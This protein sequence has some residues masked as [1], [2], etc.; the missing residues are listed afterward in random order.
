MHQRKKIQL[1]ILI[2]LLF[3]LSNAPALNT[4]QQ[5]LVISPQIALPIGIKIWFN[6]SGGSIQGLTSWN[7]GES[8]AS[9][10]IGHFI[11]YPYPGRSTEDGFPRL[12]RYMESHGIAVP[13][14]LRGNGSSFCPWNNRY[15]FYLAQN[16]TRMVELRQFLQ[17]TI[18]VQ[19]EYMSYHLAETFPQL[20]A[21]AP[22]H[23]RPYICEQFYK[24]ARTPAG[25]YALVDYLNFKGA[26]I[27]A[28]LNHHA[29]GSG[30]VQVLEGMKFAPAGSSLLQAYVWSAKHALIRRVEHSPLAYHEER[31][32]AGWFKRLN[33]YLEG[34]M[35][36]VA[37]IQN[38]VRHR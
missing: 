34:D 23:E 26:G 10:G 14:W 28:S 32:L 35:E 20:L 27:G 3:C 16:S 9:L 19:A 17:Q 11:W 18:P 30:L 12:I 36:Q 37:I 8:F 22:T 6:E 2:L 15:E 21:S 33:T 1:F 7:N 25:I 38:G 29:N 13:W 24:L 4:R 31:W 5:A